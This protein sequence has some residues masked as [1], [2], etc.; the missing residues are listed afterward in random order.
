MQ[1]IEEKN[2]EHIENLKS[3][4]S[5]NEFDIINYNLVENSS[6]KYSMRG[7]FDIDENKENKLLFLSGLR[8]DPNLEI[9]NYEPNYN[10]VKP[11]IQSFKF[12]KDER[13]KTNKSESS[14]NPKNT[15]KEQNVSKSFD[16]D[17]LDVTKEKE[18]ENET[19]M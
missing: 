12:P 18:K 19:N 6:P 4:Q 10:Y 5:N 9:K 1:Q 16:S 15:S 14:L 8:N 3:S 13:F 11:R 7:K 2:K 17:I